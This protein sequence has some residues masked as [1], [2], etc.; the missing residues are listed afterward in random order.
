MRYAAYAGS[1]KGRPTR[2]HG[3]DHTQRRA[4]TTG[5][6]KEMA[7][8]EAGTAGTVAVSLEPKALTEGSVA[9]KPSREGEN[10]GAAVRFSKE[11]PADIQVRCSPKLP[12]CRKWLA[13]AEKRSQTAQASLSAASR[14]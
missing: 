3:V 12:S 5:P 2:H 7:S 8:Q 14:Q 1:G 13:L 11:P 10:A 9:G 6:L 4:I